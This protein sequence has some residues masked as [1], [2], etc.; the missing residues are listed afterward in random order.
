[1]AR[2]L[3]SKHPVVYHRRNGSCP[4]LRLAVFLHFSSLALAVFRLASLNEQQPEQFE[5]C[6][7]KSVAFAEPEA[8]VHRENQT[9]SNQRSLEC[10][11]LKQRVDRVLFVEHVDFV[12][13]L[14]KSRLKR[15]PVL[16][17]LAIVNTRLAKR[18]S[19]MFFL[20]IYIYIDR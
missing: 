17:L 3:K 19:V 2:K 8:A 12:A 11:V 6:P 13:K 18:K 4:W 14:C 7:R 10:L 1:M 16:S 5:K 20:A 15:A 9:R